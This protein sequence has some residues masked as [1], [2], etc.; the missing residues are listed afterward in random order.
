MKIILALMI[1]LKYSNALLYLLNFLNFL[2]FTF[3]HF[4]LFLFF[5]F[6][7]HLSFFPSPFQRQFLSDVLLQEFT[8]I[9]FRCGAITITFGELVDID[10]FSPKYFLEWILMDSI[11]IGPIGIE[12]S[13]IH[14]VIAINKSFQ[15]V[16]DANKFTW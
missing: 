1:S 15:F 11:Q 16:I 5:P 13:S 6:L 14:I 12:C 3:F 4:G 10:E 8:R 9:H 7:L 2:D